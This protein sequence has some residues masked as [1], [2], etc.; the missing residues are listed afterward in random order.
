MSMGENGYTKAAEEIV[1]TARY[2][3]QQAAGIPGIKVLGNPL[4]M[5]VSFAS[6]Q[7]NIYKV[8]R[9]SPTY[10]TLLYYYLGGHVVRTND[11]PWLDVEF[12]PKPCI[13]PYLPYFT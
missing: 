13:L 1:T 2:L 6:D 3:A 7:F 8:V 5:V 10:G 12:P 4:A 9:I 11:P